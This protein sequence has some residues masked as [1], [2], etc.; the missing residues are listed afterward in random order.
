MSRMVANTH[1]NHKPMKNAMHPPRDR[2]L[3]AACDLFYHQGIHAVGVDAIAAAADTNKMTLY[4]H[5]SSKDELIAAYLSYLAAEGDA[6]WDEI[7]R[8]NNNNPKQ[9]LLAWI[10]KVTEYIVNS[11][12]RG[13][14]FA[15]AAA[16]LPEK[17]HPARRVIEEHKIKYR[18][19][20]TELCR[21][22]KLSEPE[23]L[24]DKIFL[25]LEGARVSLQSLGPK[26]PGSNLV[27]MVRALLERHV[28]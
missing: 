15:N 2:I 14:A 4:R 22:A 8:V 16:E 13:C 3:A 12:G 25:L 6:A 19:K 24:A 1:K 7:A 21:E 28:S 5:F 11:G 10:N 20:I 27:D 9:Q 26:G 17:N 18:A 23:N